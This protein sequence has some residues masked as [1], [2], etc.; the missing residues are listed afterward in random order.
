MPIYARTIWDLCIRK[1]GRKPSD[2]PTVHVKGKL[3]ELIMGKTLLAKY[4]DIGNPTITVQIPNVLVDLGAT[5]NVMTIE[6]V[7]KL[8]LTNL[9]PTPIILELAD[10]CTIK[11]E[12]ILDDLVMLVDSWEYLADFL[13]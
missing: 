3:S 12:G 6:T 10:R 1:L 11:L 8:M 4:D 7:R 2:P 5:I 13:V 9:S